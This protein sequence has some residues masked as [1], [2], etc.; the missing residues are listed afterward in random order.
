MTSLRLVD[1]E[2]AADLATYLAR[3]R[4]VDEGGFVR[5][6]AVGPVLAAWTC[7]LPGR[8]LTNSGLVLGLRTFALAKPTQRDL[9]VPIGAVTDRLARGGVELQ[10]P[11]VLAAPGWSA[12]SPPRSGWERVG[13]VPDTALQDHAR[14]GIAEIARGVPEGAGSAAVADLRARVW[15]RLTDTVP[16][17]P[18]GTAFGLHALGFLRPAPEARAEVHALGPWTRVSTDRGFVI[19]R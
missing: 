19:A 1:E 13:Q 6:Q 9:T 3:A 7:V 5:L 14:D 16:P 11:P 8:G 15:M 2:S 18:A 17:V 12:V 4:R 10:D